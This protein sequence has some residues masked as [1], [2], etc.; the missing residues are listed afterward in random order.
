MIS[1]KAYRAAE[2]SK[3]EREVFNQAGFGREL[4]SDF[5]AVKLNIL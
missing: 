3:L 4:S 2:V 1:V 5:V